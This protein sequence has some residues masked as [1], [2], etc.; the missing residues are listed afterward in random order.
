MS[1]SLFSYK[2]KTVLVVGGA[3]GMGAA[4]A[5]QAASDGAEVIVLDVADVDY[6]VKQALKLDLRNK[7]NIDQVISEISGTVDVVFS[8]AGVA[9]G[10]PGIMLINFTGQRY[11]L[12]QLTAK[13]ILVRGGSI[14][15]ISSVA[16]MGWQGNLPQV[17]EFLALESWDAQVNWIE[18]HDGTDTY[19]FSKQAMNGYVANRCM[20]YAKQG[21]RINSVLPG[22]TDTPLARANADVWLAFG[23]GYR[24]QIAAQPLS[25][26][27]IGSAMMF[28][29][30]DAASGI[31][32]ISMFID[33][34]HMSA[35]TSGAYT[36]PAF[37]D[38]A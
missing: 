20:A 37:A 31:S 5:K 25:P 18:G 19:M 28:L 34:G 24:D 27:Q 16:G 35:S 9:D 11:L 3:T 1:D 30:G 17:L 13:D 29:G 8:C 22:P 10:F 33:H 2:G 32:G 38:L 36:E 23:A 6:P 26:E 21:I 14:V 4:A 15:M 7:D 12:E